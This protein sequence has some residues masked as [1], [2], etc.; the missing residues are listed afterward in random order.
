VTSKPTYGSLF[1][2][3]GGFDMGFDQAGYECQFQVEWDK[4]CQQILQK[5]WPD[6][7]KWWNVSDVNGAEL[8]PV[9]VLI[10]GSPCQDLSVAGK[11]AGL[12][13]ER[14]ILFHE[15]MRIVK[16]M[17]DATANTYPR[18]VVWENVV[19]ALTSNGGADFGVVLDEMAKAGAMVVEWAVLDAQYFGVPQRRRRVFIVSILDPSAA[20]NCPDPLL[21]VSQGMRG[22]S[23]K[24]TKKGKGAPGAPAVGFGKNSFGGW[25]ETDVAIPL[26]AR[27]TKGPLTTVVEPAQEIVGSLNTYDFDKWGSNQFVNEGKLIV[28]PFVKSRRAQTT[29]DHETWNEG[30][31][32]NTL[33]QFDLGDVRTTTAIVSTEA[34]LSFDT[35]FGSNALVF[36]DITPPLKSTQQPP[37]VALDGSAGTEAAMTV[38]RLTPVECEALMGWPPDHTRWRADGKEQVDSHRFRQCGNGVATPVAR[39]VAGHLIKVL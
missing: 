23:K 4:H 35:Q 27:D 32:T 6:V 24:G 1:A 2:G 16:E 18:A 15:A 20:A 22:D 28:Q 11:R 31:V 13:G 3:V 36:S 30:E 33:N 10:F 26:S 38:R 8:P 21:P 39:W 37:S 5:H 19:G 12:S 17:R 7:P 34:P 14:S 25:V 29:E 9:D